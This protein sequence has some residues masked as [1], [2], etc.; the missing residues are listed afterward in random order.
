M[1]NCPSD[2]LSDRVYVEQ[3]RSLYVNLA[4]ATV[5]W[6]AFAINAWLAYRSTP[7]TI[8]AVL[9]LMGMMASSARILVTRLYRTKALTAALDRAAARRLEVIF[10]VPYLALSL[11]LGL[12]ALHIFFDG[13]PEMHMLTIC[14]VVGYCAGVATTCGLRPRLAIPSML[15]AVA[16][17]IVISLFK[18][19]LAYLGMSV[20]AS[21]FVFGGC[22]S[23]R[24]RFEASKAEI[25]QRLASISLARLDALTTLPNRL[26]L[27]EY[28]DEHAALVSPNGAIAVHYLDLDGFKP[29]NDRY[30][31]AVGDALLLAVA[32]RLRGAVRSGDIV[33]RMG[34]D[35]F[36]VI[37]FGLN[38][39]DEAKLLARR[40]GATIERPFV[41]SEARIAISTSV[42]TV[43]SHDR[44]ESLASLLKAADA[45]LYE[46]KRSRRFTRGMVLSA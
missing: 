15:T 36:A 18:P 11:L 16:P 14:V 5:M 19:D 33:A 6:G 4:P 10:S 31:H 23:I 13:V 40:I 46:K 39:A 9:G 45:K 34:G 26:A 28:F 44:N 27:Q 1:P 30:G 7:D 17:T 21:A 42:G 32:E 12:F 24:V 3:V 37:Q 22:R 25:G 8:G 20:I 38:H 2:A 35:E 43:V 41:L 29:V